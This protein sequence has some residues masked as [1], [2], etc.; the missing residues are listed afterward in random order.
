MEEKK[1]PKVT[2]IGAGLAGC[3][4]AILLAQRGCRVN[5]Y[6]YR[7]DPDRAN[8]AGPS[9]RS[10]N[11]ALSTR[12]ITAL[13]K[14]GLGDKVQECGVPMHGRCVHPIAGRLQHQRYGHKGQ[15]LLSISRAEL[16]SLLL[17]KC[18]ATENLTLHFTHKC[19]G[20]DL[21]K[22][23]AQFINTSQHR[24]D[25]I[26]VKVSSD[27]VIGA[28]GTF[29]RVRTAMAREDMF[30]CSQS[31]IS[32]AYKEL[33]LEINDEAQMPKEWLHI[34]PRHRYMLIALPNRKGNFT[35]TLFMD[36]EEFNHLIERKTIEQ[37]FEDNFPDAARL[38]P[39]VA[40]EFL[41]NPTPSLVTIRCGPYHF[42]DKAL[43][44][45]DAAHA[46]VPFYGQGC[47][48]AFEDC[49]I[50]AETIDKFGWDDIGLLFSEFTRLRK[51]NA[52]AI[53]DLA[54]DNYIDMASRT[55]RPSVVLLRKLGKFANRLFPKLWL[56]LYSMISFSNIPYAE[57]VKRAERQDIILRNVVRS[58]IALAAIAGA[59]QVWRWSS[60]Q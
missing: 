18:R 34:W 46:I 56:P 41:Q 47:N 11:L 1:H 17:E 27:F 57:A 60:R 51:E 25:L 24:P 35:C 21:E 28:D 7:S 54:L 13:S 33:S 58:T 48:A 43:L 22:A 44:I 42:R 52:D 6:E 14:A 49:R 39:S 4:S 38:M 59:T 8:S 2:V 36:R 15:F 32:A 45:G 40:E 53:A 26:N 31:Y 20:V 19:I 3:L 29:S 12:G 23:T 30:D 55:A 5:V 10:I 16:N 37:F 9:Q 50:L